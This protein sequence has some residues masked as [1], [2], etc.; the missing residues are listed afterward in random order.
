MKIPVVQRK[1]YTIFLERRHGL[2]FVHCDVYVWNKAVKLQLDKDWETL[3]SLHNETLYA[4]HVVGDRKHSKFL[5]MYGFTYYCKSQAANLIEL[6]IYRKD[7][8]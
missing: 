4:T 5:K 1:E 2:S 3:C 8:P 7:I 6:E